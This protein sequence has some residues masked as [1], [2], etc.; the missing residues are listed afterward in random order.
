MKIKRFRPEINAGSMAD[1]AFLLLVFFLV[2]TTMNKDEG[3]QRKLPP[4]DPGPAGM[5]AQKNI[6]SVLVNSE[7]QILVEDEY[8]SISEI[9]DRAMKF[10]DNNGKSECDY[11]EGSKNSSSSDH[12]KQAIISL[13]N[14]RATSYKTYVS[15]QNE[16]TAAYNTLR[17][18]L[19]EKKYAQAFEDLS[20]NLQK[21]ISEAYPIIISEAVTV[22]LASN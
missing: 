4:M 2:A 17:N 13:Q 12:P 3:I 10:I 7:N 19:A 20:P 22:D 14:D 6:L 18:T 1:I 21:E 11:C 8:L 5:V 9:K 15:V 16:L